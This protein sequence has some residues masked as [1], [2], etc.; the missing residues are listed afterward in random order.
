[1]FYLKTKIYTGVAWLSSARVVRCLVNSY[2][3]SETL[4]FY[5][6]LRK[7]AFLNY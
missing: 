6:L 5:F 1:M 7:T 4:V 2:L 3:T